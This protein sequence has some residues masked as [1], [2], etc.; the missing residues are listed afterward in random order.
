MPVGVNLDLLV[1]QVNSNYIFSKTRSKRSELQ[2]T[3]KD[4]VKIDLHPSLPLTRTLMISL[5][6]YCNVMLRVS[7]GNDSSNNNKF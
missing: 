6:W 1:I 4:G 3:E 5:M 7:D 2:N